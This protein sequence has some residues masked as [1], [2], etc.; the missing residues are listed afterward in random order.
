[1]L[2][3][4]LY[5]RGE[6]LDIA[7]L[8]LTAHQDRG[9]ITPADLARLADV[10]PIL[11]ALETGDLEATL[12]PVAELFDSWLADRHLPDRPW[13]GVS[14]GS[15]LSIIEVHAALVL[16]VIAHQ[17][18]CRV[19]LGGGNASYLFDFRGAFTDLWRAVL[20]RFPVVSG[21]GEQAL[22]AFVRDPGAPLDSPGVVAR[23][24]VG[25]PVCRPVEAAP[26]LARPRFHG[27]EL[28]R[29]GGEGGLTLPYVFD[30]GCR[31]RCAFCAQSRDP[32]PIAGP[33][34]RA[35][36]V[37]EDLA[38]LTQEHH[39]TSFMLFDNAFNSDVG[40]AHDI[41]AGLIRRKLDLRWSDCARF[42]GLDETLLAAMRA[43]GCDRLT[44][45]LESA[46]PSVL[47]RMGKSLDLQG[48]SEA[49]TAASR[50][51]IECHLDVI[52]GLPGEQDDDVEATCRFLQ[53]HQGLIHS[54][55]VNRL[56][57]TPSSLLGQ[58]PERYRLRLHRLADGHRHVATR[59]RRRLEGIDGF[60]EPRL[61]LVSAGNTHIYS[62]SE[63]DGRDHRAVQ[64]E[65]TRRWRRVVGAARAVA[66]PVG[67]SEE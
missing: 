38:A 53:R 17:A 16:A 24:E 66:P 2:A 11:R 29:Y 37:V 46:S 39:T 3:A 62:Y 4:H 14:L 41:C 40:R 59:T 60:D 31:L 6:G 50:I 42:A 13:V 21:P 55:R 15:D 25:S 61:E 51:G 48:A 12:H 57:I 34:V 8:R 28:G 32:Q 30:P 1:M 52:V 65:T 54:I 18:G 26:L 47:R 9:R 58:H 22:A 49:L 5:E 45:G 33:S 20:E 56:Y 43:A 23:G 7:D 35:D 19:V 27:F 10:D 64:T 63:I 67:R 44:F 36:T